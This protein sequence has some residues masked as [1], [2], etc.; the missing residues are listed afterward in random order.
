LNDFVEAMK[1]HGMVG[2]ALQRHAIEGATV[3]PAGPL[4]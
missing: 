3:A 4:R 2:A 1:R